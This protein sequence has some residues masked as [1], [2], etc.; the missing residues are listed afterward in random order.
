MKINR[1][2]FGAV[3]AAMT[4][5]SLSC[6]NL[7]ESN[8]IDGDASNIVENE[9][10]SNEI[11]DDIDGELLYTYDGAE[12]W[13]TG[14]NSGVGMK[15]NLVN[16]SDKNL[17]FNFEYLAV[18]NI[19]SYCSG[20]LSAKAGESDVSII[21]CGDTSN[22][23]LRMFESDEFTNV[24]LYVF[25][26]DSDSN[27]L[28]DVSD[29]I[30]FNTDSSNKVSS[31]Y[32]G[33][34]IYNSDGIKIYYSG[35][36]NDDSDINK[37]EYTRFEIVNDTDECITVYSDTVEYDG[38]PVDM[39]MDNL[40]YQGIQITPDC[41]GY[42]YIYTS[43]TTRDKYEIEDSNNISISFD[44]KTG[45]TEDSSIKTDMINIVRK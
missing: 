40:S 19:A 26:Y 22:Y 43:K 2:L 23:E 13:Y 9:T 28:L 18:N 4:M 21:N 34:E 11:S 39:Y 32:S 1:F 15:V 35:Y 45:V 33:E 16:K 7:S 31:E 14:Y 38:I 20:Y 36:Y 3:V 17:K 8:N 30:T 5:T 25:C 27:E 42:G 12:L 6:G 24:S 41:K 37:Y 29:K 44:I 10:V